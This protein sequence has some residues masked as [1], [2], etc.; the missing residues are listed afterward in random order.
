MYMWM[1]ISMGI[2]KLSIIIDDMLSQYGVVCAS[3]LNPRPS[4]MD[5]I[6]LS[7]LDSYKYAISYKYV[8]ILKTVAYTLLL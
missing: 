8:E 5:L 3:F 4:S 1:E 2:L 7:D 6:Y